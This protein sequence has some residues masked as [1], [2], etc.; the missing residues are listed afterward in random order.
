[1]AATP[2]AGFRIAVWYW[3]KHKLNALADAGDFDATTKRIN[4]GTHGAEDR[5]RRHALALKALGS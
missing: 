1:M 4:G 3:T 2:E 5:R